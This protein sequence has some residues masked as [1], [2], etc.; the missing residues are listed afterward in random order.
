[1]G[2]IILNYKCNN[3]TFWMD[4]FNKGWLIWS[5]WCWVMML[6]RTSSR[7]FKGCITYIIIS[8]NGEKDFKIKCFNLDI[9]TARKCWKLDNQWGREKKC[10]NGHIKDIY[11][12]ELKI[13]IPW[14]FVLK[15]GPSRIKSSKIIDLL[16][17]V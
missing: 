13:I 6:N 4:N 2:Q 8:R 11:D 9:F 10:F 14:V 15:S 3:W 5:D 12:K 7:M 16:N 1:M 17:C